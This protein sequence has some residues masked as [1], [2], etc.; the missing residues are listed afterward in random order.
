MKLKLIALAAMLAAGSANAAI[1]GGNVNTGNGELFFSI[2]DTTQSYTRDLNVSIDAFQTSLAAAGNLNLSFAADATFTS[3]LAGVA[4][5]N[6]LK[7]NIIATDTSGAR[8]NLTTY[9]LPEDTTP[10]VAD[11]GRSMAGGI[12]A[13]INNI[14]GT[15]GFNSNGGLAGVGGDSA[16]FLAS[17]AG[18]TGNDIS[19]GTMLGNKAGFDT[20]GTVARNSYATGLGFMRVD[21]AAIGTAVSGLNEYSDNAFAVNAWLDGGNTLHIAAAVAPVPEPETYALMLAGLGLVGFMARR[22]KI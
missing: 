16:I 2:W 22:R 12:Q 20:T 19:F 14:N 6:A 3:F 1:D 9:T 15:A 17:D 13:K 7:W 11:I 21:S 18:Y 8:R 4:D 5:V 10:L